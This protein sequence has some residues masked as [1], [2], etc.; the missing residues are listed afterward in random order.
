MAL[1]TGSLMFLV[2]EWF[3]LNFGVLSFFTILEKKLFKVS[4]FSDSNVSILSFHFPS[5]LFSLWIITCER[6]KV[7]AGQICWTNQWTG[8]YMISA[9]V[10]KGL[11]F[12]QERRTFIPL[13]YIKLAGFFCFLS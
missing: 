2:T 11:T 8:F 12:F 13:F 1:K 3:E 7:L 9:S 10:M 4:A 6:A 5:D